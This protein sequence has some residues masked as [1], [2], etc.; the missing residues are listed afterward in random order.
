MFLEMVRQPTASSRRPRCRARE[1]RL[2]LR[3]PVRDQ[4]P[5]DLPFYLR[6]LTYG[7]YSQYKSFGIAQ[8]A[9]GAMA[10][11][12]FPVRR[13][14]PGPTIGD[15]ARACTPP[16]GSWPRCGSGRPRRG[17]RVELSMQDAI[18]NFC[19]VAMRLA[20]AGGDF[21]PRR[22]NEI[23][24][25]AVSRITMQAGGTTTLISIP[26]PAGAPPHVGHAAQGGRPGGSH[27]QSGVVRSRSGGSR[28]RT[29]STPS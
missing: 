27:R 21:D 11:T 12:G 15:S 13:S 5:A 18:V 7:P 3:R 6:A 2:R 8:A 25:T 22:G 17:Q 1:I 10:L 16:S 20:Y 28:T 23:A 29:R 4:S 14:S 19:R 26:I 9:G 24:N